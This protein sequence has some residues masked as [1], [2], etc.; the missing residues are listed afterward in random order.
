M[1]RRK[2]E[3]WLLKRV[4]LAFAIGAALMGA[5]FDWR[6]PKGFPRPAVPADNPMSAAKVELGRRLF[7]DKRISVNGKAS[8]GT[9]HRQDLAF[10]DGLARAEGT[11]GQVHPRSSMSLVNVAYAPLLTWANPTLD[12]LEEQAVTPMLGEE[13]IELGLKGHEQEFLNLLRSDPLYQRLFPKAFPEVG[14][15]YTLKNVTKAIAAFERTIISMRS[16]Y[17]RYRWGGDS[18]AISDSAK[19]GEL[20]FSSSERGGCFQCHGGWNFTTIRFDGKRDGR[21]EGDPRGGF[22]NTGVSLYAP[23]NRGL[24][25]RTLRLEDVGKFRAPSLRNIA[26]TA[27][28][29]HDGSLTTLE[30]VIDH[31]AAGGKMDHPNKSRILRPFRLTDDEKRDLIEF[32]KSLTDEELLHDPRWS[33]PWTTISRPTASK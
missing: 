14:D 17:D 2:P 1:T 5:D 30:E 12:S 8:C 10:T 24:Y 13:P 18:S 27:P 32:L 20:L 16:P 25:E 33:D 7:Y 29:M 4:T 23:P 28:Y 15:V 22:F 9:C 21:A 6:L 31:Y 26:L 3:R 19:R 11:T